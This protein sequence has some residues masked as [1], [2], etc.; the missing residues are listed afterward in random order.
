MVEYERLV[1][2]SKPKVWGRLALQRVTAPDPRGDN[3]KGFLASFGE[4]EAE[5]RV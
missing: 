3:E 1:A 5:A 2:E 4:L